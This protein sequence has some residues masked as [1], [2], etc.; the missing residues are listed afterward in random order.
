VTTENSGTRTGSTVDAPGLALQLLLEDHKTLCEVI[1]ALETRLPQV[2]KRDPETL[3]LLANLIDYIAEY[4]D[5]VH[6]PREDR[7]IERLIDKGLTP[8]ERTVVE[9]TV[10]QHAELGAAT[11]RMEVD[12]DALLSKQRDAG[13]QLDHD[14]RVYLAM[15]KEHMRREEQQ[16]F[17]MAVRLFTPA[18]WS[19]IAA[20][21]PE[22]PDPLRESRLSR[23]AS[24]LALI[25]GH[26]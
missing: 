18:D 13:V 1:D 3:D 4:P 5:R 14:A 19:E 20:G 16:L 11:A 25:E 12:M 26:R 23:Y 21:E 24:L 9:L 6:H 17:P 10:S 7:I 15:Q 22:V 2:S 8:S